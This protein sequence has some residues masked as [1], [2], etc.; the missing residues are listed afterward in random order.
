MSLSLVREARDLD[1]GGILHQDQGWGPVHAPLTTQTIQDYLLTLCPRALLKLH[2]SEGTGILMQCLSFAEVQA[3]AT[4]EGGRSRVGE[5]QTRQMEGH[6]A[7][8]TT[9]LV[10]DSQGH[11]ALPPSPVMV[12]VLHN[13]S[14]PW[15]IIILSNT[16]QDIM[17]NVFFSYFG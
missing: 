13:S 8:E 10:E 1:L 2:D 4:P 7:Q 15:D 9:V 16:C 14:I 11:W 12:T 17:M 3:Q 5:R 6:H